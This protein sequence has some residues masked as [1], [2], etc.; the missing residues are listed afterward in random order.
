MIYAALFTVIIVI[1]S[2]ICV[3]TA[4][5]FTLQ[6]F[7]VY[8]AVGLLG[9]RTSAASI[10][11]FMLLAA[12]GLPVFS[13]FRGG[14][15]AL[16]G[17]TGGYVVGFLFIPLAYAVVT[18]LASKGTVSY[19]VSMVIS[20][21]ICYAFGTAWFVHVYMTDSGG[22]GVAAALGMCVLPFIIPDIAKLAAATVLVAKLKPRIARA[23]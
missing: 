5:P 11:L 13:G 2:W 20:T 12:V 9:P 16:L 1:C 10:G 7:A 15:G 6:T 22:V 14:L 21:A 23:A 4:V 3:P 19:V 8:C 18:R 17:P